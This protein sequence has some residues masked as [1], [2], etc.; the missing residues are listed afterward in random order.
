M[1]APV[2]GVDALEAFYR[3]ELNHPERAMTAH[4]PTLRRFASQCSIVAEFGVKKGASSSALL[5]GAQEVWS[6]DIVETKSAR[7]LARI[8]GSRWHY[9]IQSS[10]D[11]V[12][13]SH[14]SML[15][16]DS[17]HTFAQCDS[18]LERHADQVSEL[19]VFH[20]VTT[21]G[22]VGA[23]GETGRQ[24]WAYE[25]G[26]TVPEAHWGIRPAIDRL[27]I[28]DRSW[29]ILRRDVHGH[30]LLVLGRR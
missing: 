28:R 3:D 20:D 22:E 9:Q 24:S 13:P 23:L 10:L 8:A 7:N 5:L 17:L 14:C 30:G 12:L 27:M 11:A 16:I 4:L 2:S 15:F 21:F 6:W 26:T 29:R 25:P 19:L 18:E 1:P